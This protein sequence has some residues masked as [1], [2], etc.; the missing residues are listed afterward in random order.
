M[1]TN[2]TFLL[3]VALMTVVVVASNVLVQYPLPGSIA[4]MQLGDLLTWGAFSYPVAF[5]VTDLT[6]RQ[7]GPRTARKV[8]VAGFV[9]AIFLSVLVATPRIAIASGSAFLLGQFLDISVFN[10][11]RRQSWWRAPLIGSL[12]GSLLDTAIFFSF[13]FASVFALFGPNDPF[14]LESAPILG[15]MTA[16]APRWVSWALGDLSVKILVGLAMLLPYGALMSVV[17]PMPAVK[18]PA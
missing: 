4:G 1:L 17:R 8:V 10:R 3:Y 12:F 6:N 5:L 2:R 18:A 7:F 15:L 13:A 14:A 9:V 11:L 16:E